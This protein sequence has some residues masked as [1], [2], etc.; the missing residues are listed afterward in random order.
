MRNLE[1]TIKDVLVE[2]RVVGQRVD[3]LDQKFDKLD[4]KVSGL[5]EKVNGL[6]QDVAD[7]GAAMNVFA[8][9][10][11][12]RFTA[13]DV[14]F[15]QV[16]ARLDKFEGRVDDQF[17][18]VGQQFERMSAEI[19]DVRREVEKRSSL[20]YVDKQAVAI[21][22]DA[23]LLVRKEDR[24]VAALVEKLEKKQI[25]SAEDRQDILAMEPFPRA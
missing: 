3:K 19:L 10:V 13:I 11:D 1:P 18:Q 17:E 24:K 5:D 23:V 20:D 25:F 6:Q 8:A 21:Q 2:I 22:G 4:K 9:N 15:E 14:R 16:D 12:A 7:L